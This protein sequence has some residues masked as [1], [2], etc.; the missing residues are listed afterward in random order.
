MS[1]LKFASKAVGATALA[2]GLSFAAHADQIFKVDETPYGGGVLTA[3]KLNGGY[4]EAITFDGLGGFVTNAYADFGLF[5]LGANT[6]SSQLETSYK[7]Y[8]IFSDF[9]SVNVIAPGLFS[10]SGGNGGFSLYL[11]VNS[12]TTKAL[13]ATGNDPITLGNNG[14]DLLLATATNMV[15]SSGI[16][17]AGIGGF[18]DLVFNDFL[19]TSDGANY[20]IEPNP[21][22]IVVNVDGDFDSFAVAGTQTI[23]GDVSAVFRVPEPASLALVGLALVGAGFASRRKAA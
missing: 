22:H 14:D 4:V 16:L 8:G 12:D 2:M 23:R 5:F 17:V 21:F 10:F 3:D 18:F 11:D 15:Q 19:L 13:G 20:F 1:L 6:V 9:G 7:L